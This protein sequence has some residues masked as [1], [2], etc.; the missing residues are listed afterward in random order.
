MNG[1][2]ISVR[3]AVHNRSSPGIGFV[4]GIIALFKQISHGCS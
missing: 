2:W 1:S 3:S 4:K